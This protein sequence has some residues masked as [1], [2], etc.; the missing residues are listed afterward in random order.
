MKDQNNS[1][2]F[3]IEKI[4]HLFSIVHTITIVSII[5]I[6]H[7]IGFLSNPMNS[8]RIFPASK[9]TEVN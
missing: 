2:L 7:F 8:H 1:I 3:L 4:I 5:H 6:H 9:S